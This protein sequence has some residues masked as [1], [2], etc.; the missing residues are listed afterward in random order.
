MGGSTNKAVAGDARAALARGD[1]AGALELLTSDHSADL[2]A[3]E[4]VELRAQA[5][6]GLGDFEGCVTAWEELHDLFQRQ[7]N[8][9][10]AARAAAM[11]AMYLMM[12]SGLMAAVRGWLR[13]ARRL[14]EGAEECP[15]NAI[16]AMCA[17]YERFM[18][19]DMATAGVEAA[20]AVEIGERLGVVPAVVIGR[21]CLARVAVFDGRLDEGIEGLDEVAA[22][23]MSNTVDPLTTGMMYCEL[24]CAAQGLALH[25]RASAWTETMEQWRHGVAFG[26]IN[27]RCRVHRAEILRL[28]GPCDAAEVEALAA[29]EELRPW[30]RREFGWPLAELGNIRLRKGDLDGADEAFVAAHAHGW[31]PQPG[32]ALLRLEQ[33][34]VTAALALIGAEIAHPMNFPSKERPP[35]GDLRLVPLL[36]A[37]AEIAALAGDVG[38][39]TDAASRLRRIADAYPGVSI[40][41]CAALAAARAALL[42]GDLDGAVTGSEAA[43]AAWCEVGAPFETASARLVLAQARRRA[44]NE[45]GAQLELEAAHRG[46]ADF[47]AVGRAAVVSGLLSARRVSKRSTDQSGTFRAEGGSRIVGMGEITIAVRDL[48]G[49]QYIERLLAEPDREFHVLDLVGRASAASNSVAG[50]A[51]GLDLVSAGVGA[52]LPAIDEAA[53]SAYRRRLADIEDDLDDARACNDQG[54]IELAERDREYLL[55]ELGRAVGLDGSP[56]MT[57]GSA[58][59]ARTSVARS[60]RY[61]L[62]RLR[63][64]DELLAGHLD[65]GIH[66]G[67][68]CRYVG[69]PLVQVEWRL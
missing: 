18:C 12:D 66:T 35:F 52:G 29:C 28:S 53:R 33:G 47:G 56:R 24:I 51:E 64:H 5:T 39:A 61:A 34:E 30:M 55:A 25:D 9:V 59:R 58:E 43:I 3:A 19:G 10:E 36:A 11:V 37:Q 7:S 63:E 20:R 38:V 60:I 41:A 17:G 45:S 48:K 6:Y 15:A 1:W 31:S 4:R 27:G 13:R 50:S 69:D 8:P 21:V 67:T 44:G 22:L 14:V 65:Q 32:L 16:V 40:N 57:G 49:Y 23:L 2:S 68:Y 26:G 54:R 62:D 46:F 42:A